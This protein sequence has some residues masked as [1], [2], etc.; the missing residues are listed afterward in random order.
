VARVGFSTVVS[1]PVGGVMGGC[2]E[3]VGV[4]LVF[5]VLL[6]AWRRGLVCVPLNF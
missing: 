5:L 4:F 1:E 3:G 6:L 2:V